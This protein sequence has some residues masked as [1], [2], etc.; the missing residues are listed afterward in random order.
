ME[1]TLYG[2]WIARASFGEEKSKKIGS[3]IAWGP[4]AII[5]NC[6]LDSGDSVGM[7]LTLG[8]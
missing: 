2:Q 1:L 5:A 4:I 8:M 3:C 6:Y 7:Q